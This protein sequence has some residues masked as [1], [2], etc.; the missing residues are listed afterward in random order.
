M[1]VRLLLGVDDS[2]AL[3][4]LDILSE[5]KRFACCVLPLGLALKDTRFRYRPTGV[6]LNLDGSIMVSSDARV[7]GFGPQQSTHSPSLVAIYEIP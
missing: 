6:N 4:E 1:Q 2:F 5:E 3:N 7:I